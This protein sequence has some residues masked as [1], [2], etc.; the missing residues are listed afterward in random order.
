[1]DAS[2]VLATPN[3]HLAAWRDTL[4]QARARVAATQ[5]VATS[6]RLTR[7][8]GL[9]L[10]A[11]G[12]QLPV[13]SDCLIELPAGRERRHAE[14][15]VVGFSGDRLFLMPQSEVAGLLPGARVF[16][17]PPVHGDAS[18]S[19][20]KQLPAGHR[21]LGRVVDAGGRPLDGAGP[22]DFDRKV[23]L[24]SPPI[25]PLSR[26]PI[27]S[28]LDVGVRAINAMLTVGRGQRMGLFAGSGV[29]KSVLLGM[30]ARYTSAE[31][32]VVALIGERGREVKEFIEHT[33]GEQ[34]LARSVVVAAPADTSPL[35]R[36]QGAA[37]ATSLA[38]YFRDQGRHV[39]L[40][41]DSLTRYA[42]AQREIALAVG[43]P[44]ATKG[45]PP[46]V[47]ARLPALVER[48][49]NGDRDAHG[50]GGSITAFYTVLSEGDDQQDPIADAARAILDGHVVL[51]RTLAEAG[52]Y[53]AIDIEASISRAMT[54]LVDPA[55]FE[56]VRRFK[57]TLSRYQRNR[58]LIGVGAY[59]PGHDAQLDE[60]I[61]LYPR[62]EAFL[63]QPMQE[64]TAYPESVA[65]LSRIFAAT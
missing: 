16:A 57:Q 15:E 40:I 39:L 22:L 42:M 43:E 9:V 21:M 5:P 61:A 47:F 52:H 51:S 58:D 12:L 4:D 29:G 44:P 19:A 63:Q 48:A 10:E 25:N 37:Y 49:G 7:A 41:M 65:Q 64:R 26:A 20:A 50:K 45:Y 56:V 35:L 59:S 11:V 30:M 3:P 53:P 38:E 23:A 18:S 55:Q 1:M 31:V 14:A 6:G 34:G 32:I 28:V 24:T 60:A 36:L 46:S 62:L 54:S 13:G 33:L 8:V 2:S 17:L 27:D